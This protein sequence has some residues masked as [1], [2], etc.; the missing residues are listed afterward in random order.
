MSRDRL[1]GLLIDNLGS[2]RKGNQ[3]QRSAGGEVGGL[4]HYI[5]EMQPLQLLDAQRMKAKRRL[6]LDGVI[7]RSGLEG[8]LFK[9]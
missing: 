5:V 4:H 8:F 7:S 6:G 9:S 2:R 3:K 1:E